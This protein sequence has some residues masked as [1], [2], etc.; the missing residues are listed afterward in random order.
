ML[1]RVS[2]IIEGNNLEEKV[3]FTSGCFCSMSILENALA[4]RAAATLFEKLSSRFLGG[5]LK[6]R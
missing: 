2:E 4:L 6:D 5:W 1:T 3:P